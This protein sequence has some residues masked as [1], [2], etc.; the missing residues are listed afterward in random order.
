MVLVA[1]SDGVW[2][3]ALALLAHVWAVESRPRSVKWLLRR[4]GKD[5]DYD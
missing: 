4:K 2:L 5:C 3:A 1:E